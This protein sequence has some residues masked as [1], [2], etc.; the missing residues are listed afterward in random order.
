MLS[1]VGALVDDVVVE[2]GGGGT[3]AGV[4]ADEEELPGSFGIIASG[5]ALSLFWGALLLLAVLG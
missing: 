4:A 1:G 5:A 2:I 3:A